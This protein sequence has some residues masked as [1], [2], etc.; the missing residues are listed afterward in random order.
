MCNTLFVTRP[1]NHEN[2]CKTR[3]HL[4]LNKAT[5]HEGCQDSCLLRL[6][7]DWPILY[8]YFVV[9]LSPTAKVFTQNPSFSA[10]F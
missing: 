5:A 10:Q 3:L 1:K 2:L 8:S 6:D 9:L 7:C 4:L